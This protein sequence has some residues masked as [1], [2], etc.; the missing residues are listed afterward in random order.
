MILLG[1]KSNMSQLF[2]SC[3]LILSLSTWGEGFPNVIG[4]AM[5]CGLL[6]LSTDVGDSKMVVDRFGKIVTSI[7]LKNIKRG[8]D[9]LIDMSEQNRKDLGLQGRQ[10]IIKRFEIDHIAEK[11]YQLYS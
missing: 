9:E 7:D 10:S 4:E 5:S 8:V 1:E 2:S 3:D 11:Y 6:V